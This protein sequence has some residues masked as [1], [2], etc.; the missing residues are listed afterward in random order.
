MEGQRQGVNSTNILRAAC[1]LKFLHQKKV[2]T[3]NVNSSKL[4]AKLFYEK[5]ACKMLVKLVTGLH[6]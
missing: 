1:G 5:A 6:D 2:Q 3:K 4:Q